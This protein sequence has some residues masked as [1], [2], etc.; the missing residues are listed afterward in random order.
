MAK[1]I[2]NTGSAANDGTGDN[3]RTGGSKVNDN[4]S[5]IY[6][7]LGDGTN[8]LNND[9]DFGPNKLLFANKVSSLNDLTLIN[10]AGYPGLIIQVEQTGAL[11]YSYSGSWR[12][13]LSDTSENSIP[14]YDDP[15]SSVAYSGD[16]NELINKPSVPTSITDLSDVTDGSAGQVLTTDGIGNFTFRDITATNVTF[17][18]IINKPTTI[19]GY[20]I[21]DAFSGNYDDLTNKPVIFSG[22]YN[23]LINAPLVATDIS[24]LDDATNLLFSKSYIDLTN[25]PAIPNDINDLADSENLLFSGSYTDLTN[26]PTLFTGLSSI[27]LSIGVNIDEF[28][29]D[30]TLAGSSDTTVPTE[31]A[32]KSYVDNAVSVFSVFDQDLN[33]SDS[34]EFLSVAATT[35]TPTNTIKFSSSTIKGIGLSDNS[36]QL[37]MYGTDSGLGEN[38]A[39]INTNFEVTGD[40]TATSFIGSASGL[41]GLPSTLT[42]LGITD[43]TV[44]QVLT[45]NGSGTFT[46]QNPGDQIGNF[47]LAAS[48]IDTDDSSAITITPAVTMASDLIVENDLVVNGSIVTESSGTP[49]VFSET[50]IL[51]T[52]TDRVEVTQSPFKLASFTNAQ[53]DNLTPEFGDTIYNSETGK[54]QAYV[55]DTG[56]S[57]PG[58]VDLH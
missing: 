9:I 22:D 2:I 14:S 6:N 12:R 35:I 45:T 41:T 24:E 5:E 28:S 57:T 3:L 18:A 51:L 17:S 36:V 27:G 58:W 26:K 4:F 52:A 13:L 7:I 50:S 37:L 44:G 10:A 19:S 8:L 33:S 29:N 31:N 46:F 48:V 55:G 53:R 25:K 47:T 15:I 43:G 11:Y 30:T 40:V 21:V 56:D 34:V 38:K 49:E 23:D 16:Y 1:K 32:V 20:G 42:D 39:T 54:V